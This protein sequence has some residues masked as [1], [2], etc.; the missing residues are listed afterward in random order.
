MNVYIVTCAYTKRFAINLNKEI[1]TAT[2]LFGLIKDPVCDLNFLT[3]A[4]Q[5]H[6]H[7][8]YVI[9]TKHLL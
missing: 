5:T 9:K 3:K 7:T 8:K 1:V 4:E 6:C 2:K